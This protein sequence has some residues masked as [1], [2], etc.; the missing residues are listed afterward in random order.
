VSQLLDQMRTE[1][2]ARHYSRRTEQAYCL[3]VDRYVRY[4]GMRHP[5][6]WALP[7]STHS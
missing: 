4:N 2:R 5:A 3:W 7:R 6:T 1:L